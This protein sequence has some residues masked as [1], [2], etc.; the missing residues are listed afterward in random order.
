MPADVMFAKIVLADVIVL[1]NL[2][3][4][5]ILVGMQLFIYE[6]QVGIEMFWIVSAQMLYLCIHMRQI[7]RV[8]LQNLFDF[9][10][11]IFYFSVVLE[12]ATIVSSAAI[13]VRSAITC[14]VMRSVPMVT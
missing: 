4:W 1:D 5:E 3:I 10:N 12:T 13:V 8:V 11:C 14:M 2:Y 7:M 9:V 6:V